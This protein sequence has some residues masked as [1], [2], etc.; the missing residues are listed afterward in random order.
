MSGDHGPCSDIPACGECGK[1]MVSLFG[2]WLCRTW[3]CARYG[4]PK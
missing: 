2:R 3:E 4:G 1:L